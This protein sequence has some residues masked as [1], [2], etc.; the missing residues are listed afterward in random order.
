M[1]HLLT[2][3]CFLISLNLFAANRESGGVGNTKSF[4]NCTGE[5]INGETVNFEIR[6]TAVPTFIDGLLTLAATNNK[7]A[8]LEC[9][10]AKITVSNTPSEGELEWYCTEYKNINDGDISIEIITGEATGLLIGKIK[11]KQIFPLPSKLIGTLLCN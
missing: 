8:Q 11:Q 2:I 4:A 6:S 7:V 10:K 9:K 5:L 3:T 1:K